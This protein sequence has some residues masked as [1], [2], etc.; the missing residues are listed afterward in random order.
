MSLW[1]NNL[2]GSSFVMCVCCFCPTP[3]ILRAGTTSHLFISVSLSI[4]AHREVNQKFFFFF[5]FTGIPIWLPINVYCNSSF[6]TIFLVYQP[7]TLNLQYPEL[8]DNSMNKTFRHG[9]HVLRLCCPRW[10]P[11][12]TVSTCHVVSATEE[13]KFYISFCFK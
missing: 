1:C 3:N 4:G 13:L 5:F 6:P 2:Y 8:R 12:A 9:G 10:Q 7:F 11:L